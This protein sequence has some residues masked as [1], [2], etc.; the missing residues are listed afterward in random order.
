MFYSK[1]KKKVAVWQ[2]EAYFPTW[3][4]LGTAGGTAMG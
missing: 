1:K 4:Q 2:D 3:Q